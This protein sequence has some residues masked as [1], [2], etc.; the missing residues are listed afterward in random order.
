MTASKTPEDG[1]KIKNGKLRGVESCGMMCS[2]EELGSS[3]EI[4]IRK[5]RKTAFIFSRK[6]HK[7][8]A[9]AQSRLLDLDDVVV[10][11]EITSNRVDCYSVLGIA[12][13]AAATFGKNFVPPVVEVN[14]QQRRC[15]RLYQSSCRRYRS[16]LPLL[17]KSGKKYQN[18]TC[19]RNG[20]SD[21]W[22]PMASARSTTL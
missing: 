10:E 2:I 19:L 17:R 14:R 13:E 12:R 11:Y 8:G 7:V 18:R 1:I 9:D 3:T 16:V 4:C 6:M 20:C 15:Q 21:V 22:L 5:H